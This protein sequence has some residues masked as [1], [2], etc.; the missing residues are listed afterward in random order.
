MFKA[1]AVAAF[2]SAG[3]RQRHWAHHSVLGVAVTASVAAEQRMPDS[4]CMV[5]LQACG[6]N[7]GMGC[8][9]VPVCPH[10]PVKGSHLASRL[11]VCSVIKENTVPR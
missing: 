4:G 2:D 3:Q 6:K 7:W 10:L 5:V 1:V 11:L 8:S 9:S